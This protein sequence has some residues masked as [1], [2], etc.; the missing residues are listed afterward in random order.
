MKQVVKVLKNNKCL[1]EDGTR[2]EILKY[3]GTEVVGIVHKLT[4]KVERGKDV[5][6]MVTGDCISYI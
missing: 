4:T 1:V 3:W 6:E 2:S 5:I